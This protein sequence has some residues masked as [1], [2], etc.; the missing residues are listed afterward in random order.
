MSDHASGT[1]TD[2]HDSAHGGH[3]DGEHR[4]HKKHHHKAHE[5]HEHEEGWIVS[6]ADN[7]LL[8]MGFFVILLAMNMGP[9]GSSEASGATAADDRMLDVAI[10]V[11]EAFH[12]PLDLDSKD[13]ND[14]P[15]IQ[16]MMRRASGPKPAEPEEGPR[17]DDR[18]PQSV[19]PTD[20]KGMGSYVQ[21]ADFATTLSE[22]SKETLA[23]TAQQ[24]AGSRW[25]LEIRGHASRSECRG[26]P[27]RAREL[28]YQRAWAVGVELARLGVDWDRMRLVSCGSSAPAL[29]RARTSSERATNQRTEILVLNET[30]PEDPFSRE[31]GHTGK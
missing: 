14:L 26:D 19:R 10:A 4:K 31:D 5:E 27:K 12:N 1:P 28:S 6:F 23:E 8:M 15:L 22:T 13:P 21:F 20:W 18:E 2:G 7:V 30:L 17:G 24:I 16:R 29:A 9:K 25:M 3:G 11:R